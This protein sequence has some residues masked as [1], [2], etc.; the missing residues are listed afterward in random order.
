LKHE[1]D[2]LREGTP[3]SGMLRARRR[4]VKW[5]HEFLRAGGPVRLARGK[6]TPGK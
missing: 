1:N 5:K 4:G 6:K 2:R 3:A